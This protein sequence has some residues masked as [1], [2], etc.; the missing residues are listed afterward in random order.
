MSRRFHSLRS[1]YVKHVRIPVSLSDFKLLTS[2]TFWVWDF[3]S[4]QTE[5]NLM[6]VD[7]EGRNII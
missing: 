7:M 2:F 4:L 5:G 1:Y 6:K 3:V